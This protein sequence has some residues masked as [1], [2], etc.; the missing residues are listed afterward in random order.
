MGII[1]WI[2]FGLIAGAIAKFLM[3]GKD[4][5]GII[6]TIVIGILGAIVGGWIGTAL[7]FGSV[8]GFNIGSFA[9]AV[10]GALVLL[11]LYRVVKK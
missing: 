6:V 9:I 4:P 10:I 8:S 7:G 5:G 3:P 11:F 1:A 2:I